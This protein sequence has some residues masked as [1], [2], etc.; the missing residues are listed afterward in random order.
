V[1]YDFDQVEDIILVHFDLLDLVLFQSQDHEWDVSLHSLGVRELFLFKN[2]CFEGIFK[3]LVETI[4]ICDVI[5]ENQCILLL[6][7]HYVINQLLQI[8]LLY[9]VLL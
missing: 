5:S 6:T 4:I 3:E 9:L 1:L 7:L 8:L 2:E